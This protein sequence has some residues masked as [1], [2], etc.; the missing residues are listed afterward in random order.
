[1]LL[2]FALLLL[3]QAAQTPDATLSP[4]AGAVAVASVEG[5]GVQIYRCI[6]QTGTY[7]WMFVSPEATLFVPS[8]GENTGSHSAG[9]T[10]TWKD[11]SAITG[12][13]LAKQNSP[14]TGAVPW[15]LLATKP[16]GETSGFLTTVHWVRRSDTEG[17][18]V[19]AT[20]CDTANIGV[21][22]RVPY[23]AT[24]TFYSASGTPNQK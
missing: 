8:T 24:Y 23:R 16:A 18:Q 13:V 1:M 11:G 22:L 3:A 17:G 19:P 6:P 7:T 4:P 12:S 10:W 15:L 21:T 2:P 9:P 5:R 14:R 20:G